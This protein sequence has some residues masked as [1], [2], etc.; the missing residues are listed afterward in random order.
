MLVE[1]IFLLLEVFP[2]QSSRLH[3]CKALFASSS[4]FFLPRPMRLS[5]A[6]YSRRDTK[7]KRCGNRHMSFSSF[8][9][10]PQVSCLLCWTAGNDQ[11]TG[12]SWA[13]LLLQGAGQTTIIWGSC[14]TSFLLFTPDRGKDDHSARTS[15][16]KREERKEAIGQPCLPACDVSFPRK[17]KVVFP[18]QQQ[19]QH[20]HQAVRT[21]AHALVFQIAL[22]AL[23]LFVF[24]FSR[25]DMRSCSSVQMQMQKGRGIHARRA[26]PRRPTPDGEQ[27]TKHKHNDPTPDA[28]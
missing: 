20:R 8:L 12:L 13:Q 7:P 21:S 16:G 28:A 23:S 2:C 4:F 1:P 22:T 14:L 9:F 19:Q 3:I 18:G 10:H 6:G 15:N 17:K 27:N 26:T 11:G 24:P 25:A 5:C